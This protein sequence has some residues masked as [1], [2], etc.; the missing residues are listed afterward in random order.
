MQPQFDISYSA[1]GESSAAMQSDVDSKNYT[2]NKLA[3]AK[4]VEVK[5]K[6]ELYKNDDWDMVDAMETDKDFVKKMD[7]QS[8]PPALKNKS[9][10]EIEV[11]LK[12]KQNER[13]DIQRKIAETSVKRNAFLNKERA[14][15]QTGSAEK[16]LEKEIEKIIREQVKKYRMEIPG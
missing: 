14:N 16:T 8:L 3:A 4:R 6:K 2:F 15:E 5:G 1:S 11:Y 10:K 12:V 13:G 7:K 9:E